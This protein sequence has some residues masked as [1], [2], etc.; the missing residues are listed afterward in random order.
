MRTGTTRPGPHANSTTGTRGAGHLARWPRP[1]ATR[2]E[3]AEQA[4]AVGDG[5]EQPLE[6][7]QPI[8]DA[9]GARRRGCRSGSSSWS[10]ASNSIASVDRL[11]RVVGLRPADRSGRP[12]GPRRPRAGGCH[13]VS[14]RVS[15][16]G[17]YW[18][19]MT[20]GTGPA[21]PS[22]SWMNAPLVRQRRAACSRQSSPAS[23]CE[24]SEHGA[25][26][27]LGE[28]VAAEPE[29]RWQAQVDA[30]AGR[31][32]GTPPA[33]PARTRRST[34]STSAPR[35]ARAEARHAQH[36]LVD[37]APRCSR[38]RPLSNASSRS[39]SARAMPRPSFSSSRSTPPTRWRTRI[40]AAARDA[41]CT[42]SAAPRT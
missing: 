5:V 41:P 1:S 15:V 42:G 13:G 36:Q 7:G 40:V 14:F 20:F 16:S 25:G 4:V 23:G 2:R 3:V 31:P 22:E 17:L 24:L 27:A 28:R 26:D 38:R 32:A 34:S 11:L 18:K 21:M 37:R 6:R 39:R 35:L 33:G 10:V 19:T 8:R 29:R 30:A 12:A 9:D